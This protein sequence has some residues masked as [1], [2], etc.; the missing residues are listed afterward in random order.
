MITLSGCVTVRVDESKVFL[1][2]TPHA[3]SGATAQQINNEDY[4]VGTGVKFEHF[5]LPT[6]FGELKLTHASRGNVIDRPLYVMCMGTS[7]DRYRSGQYYLN[8]VIE[9]GDVLLFDYPGYN[10]SDGAPSVADFAAA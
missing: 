4:L 9:T 5:K 3:Q 2:Q 6:D 1:P 8:R 10:G 7:G